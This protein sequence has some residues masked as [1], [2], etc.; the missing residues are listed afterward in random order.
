MSTLERMCQ[1][2]SPFGIYSLSSESNVYSELSA[3]AVGI[4][5]L[6]DT[7]STLLRENFYATAESYG[8]SIPE[9]MWGSERINVPLDTRREML[10]ERLALSDADFTVASFNKVLN[11]LGIEAE[12]HES[13]RTQQ[14]SIVVL[15]ENLTDSERSFIVSQL[16]GHLPAHLDIGVSFD[17]F[18]W[19]DVKSSSL[20]FE[21][22][23]SASMTWSEI[24]M[25][26]I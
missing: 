12:V 3:C 1:V 26:T 25:Y 4:D 16:K 14:I 13:P 21:Q 8:L 9:K 17:G 23:D 15:T 11:M 18:N 6:R 10:R 19:S 5:I 2:M 7:L 20:T 24:D 22:M